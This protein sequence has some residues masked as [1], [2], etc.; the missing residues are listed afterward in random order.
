MSPI[1]ADTAQSAEEEIDAFEGSMP[2]N[3]LSARCEEAV[4]ASPVKNM[5][6]QKKSD[7][8]SCK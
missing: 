3:D 1:F 6:P 8:D 7:P 4:D 2:A 5:P